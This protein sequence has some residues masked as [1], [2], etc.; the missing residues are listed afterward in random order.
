MVCKLLN[1]CICREF[2]ELSRYVIESFKILK[3]IK[4]LAVFSKF[5]KI[6]LLKIFFLS[7]KGN[8]LCHL[9][10]MQP[11]YNTI[12]KFKSFCLVKWSKNMNLALILG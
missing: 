7:E 9:K 3:F 10:S 12:V 2:D 6:I 4:D 1:I 5:F 11:N 8:F